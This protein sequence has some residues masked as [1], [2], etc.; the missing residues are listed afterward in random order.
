MSSPPEPREF[1]DELCQLALASAKSAPT[2]VEVLPLAGRG[3]RLGFQVAGGP[4]VVEFNAMATLNGRLSFTHRPITAANERREIHV[5]RVAKMLCRALGR[6]PLPRELPRLAREGKERTRLSFWLA[7][8]CDRG[9]IFCPV[10]LETERG[11][12]TLP[13]LAMGMDVSARPDWQE[14]SS[15]LRQN[16]HRAAGCRVEWSGQDCLLSPSFDPGVRLAFELSYRE[17]GIQ[18]P[19]S[20]LLAPGFVDFLVDHSITRVALTAHA[21]DAATFDHVGGLA[22]AYDTFW[23]GLE[24]VLA[25]G[26]EVSLQVP[27]VRETVDGLPEHLGRLAQYDAAITCF[28][29]YPDGAMHDSFTELG[30]PFGPAVAALERARRLLPARRVEIDGIPACVAPRALRE[31]YLWKYGVHHTT[32]ID[33]EHIEACERC[34]LKESCPGAAPVYLE[35]HPSWPGTPLGPEGR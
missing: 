19:G 26:L 14:L 16:Q 34:S 13:Q 10:S 18:T 12:A 35:H 22:G 31:H 3:W 11:H 5:S 2:L 32:F 20:R 23:K 24:A 25:A 29:W 17:M 8:D 4:E 15:E 7:G 21:G 27:C 30:M 6:C 33:F 28:F 1:F 9:C